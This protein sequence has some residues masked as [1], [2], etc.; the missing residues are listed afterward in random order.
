ML[1]PVLDKDTSEGGRHLGTE[2]A[3]VDAEDARI[4]NLL[5]DPHF[6][7]TNT[8]SAAFDVTIAF[9]IRGSVG[10]VIAVGK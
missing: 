6:V 3:T 10:Y 5:F 7:D 1:L 2:I 4:V 8:T 9:K